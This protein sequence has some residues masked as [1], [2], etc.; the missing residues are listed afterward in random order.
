M[1]YDTPQGIAFYQIENKDSATFAANCKKCMYV[2]SSL[3]FPFLLVGYMLM[4][5]MHAVGRQRDVERPIQSVK[6]ISLMS[7]RRP[8]RNRGH[9]VGV[10]IFG[11]KV[12]EDYSYIHAWSGP[13]RPYF[14]MLPFASRII[15]IVMKVH[16]AT[17]CRSGL[18]CG[19]E[20]I[21]QKRT[22]AKFR[23]D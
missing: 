12:K 19:V 13:S 22:Q 2:Y 23:V 17:A 14:F 15:V 3:S 1:S 16:F 5:S 11:E 9:T 7:A 6:I 10:L 18:F 20:I 4:S 21:V 8:C